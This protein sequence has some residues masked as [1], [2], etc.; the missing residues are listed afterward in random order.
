M[1]KNWIQAFR[2]RTLPL[3]IS[4]IL[5]GSFLAFRNGKFDGVLFVWALITV[6][7]LQILSNLANDL[8]DHIKGTDNKERIGPKRSTQ[9]G[10]ISKEQMKKGIFFFACLSIFSGVTLAYLGTRDMSFATQITF[11]LLALTCMLAA[12]GYTLG[13]NAYGYLGLGDLFVFL[14]FGILSVCGIYTLM[15]K[16]F[17]FVIL[18]PALSIGF[19][20]VAVLNLNNMR[21]HEN[22]AK[23]GKR[24]LVVKIGFVHAL[25]YHFALLLFPIITTVWFAATTNSWWLLLSLLTYIVLARHILFVIQNPFPEKLDSQLGKV[26][27]STF[28]YAII[29]SACCIFLL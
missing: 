15:T 1:I 16:S 6:L 23:C 11:Y 4:G 26:A 19:L 29:F 22:D 18:L 21:D 8:G 17:E 24:T 3:S 5:V 14:F 27:L 13:K 25:K 7:F 12:I 20:S 10:A 2:F 28:L 9:T